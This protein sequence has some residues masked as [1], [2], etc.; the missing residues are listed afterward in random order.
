MTVIFKGITWLGVRTHKFDSLCGFYQHTLQ[1]PEVHTEP[2]FR[3]FDLP[4]GDRLEVFSDTYR[5]NTYFSTG[6]VA[7]FSVND[8]SEAR[9]QLETHGIEFLGPI[10]GNRSQWSHFRG[11]DGN[12]YEITSR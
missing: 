10:Y 4:N 11:P 7:G 1:L 9:S 3:A 8:V 5:S 6:P 2:G 12:I